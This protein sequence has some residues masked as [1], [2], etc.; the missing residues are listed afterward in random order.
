MLEQVI[1]LVYRL[2]LLALFDLLHSPIHYQHHLQDHLAISILFIAAIALSF[3]TATIIA[4]NVATAIFTIPYYTSRI[5][6]TFAI[7]YHL[8]LFTTHQY[9]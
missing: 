6:N 2:F 1:H 8:I 4:I 9:S 5:L 7:L 3:A